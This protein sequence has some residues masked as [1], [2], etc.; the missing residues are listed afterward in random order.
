MVLVCI[1]SSFVIHIYA[2]LRLIYRSKGKMCDVT[3]GQIKMV[4]DFETEEITK[5]ALFAQIRIM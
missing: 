3:Y 5:S 4:L 1:T 2:N